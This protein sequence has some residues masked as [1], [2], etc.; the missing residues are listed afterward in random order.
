MWL[1]LAQADE[2]CPCCGEA[3][4]THKVLD[5]VVNSLKK[6]TSLRHHFDKADAVAL[7]CI[8]GSGLLNTVSGFTGGSLLID[9]LR[10]SNSS[11]Y[12]RISHRGSMQNVGLDSAWDVGVIDGHAHSH[13]VTKVTAGERL[14][15]GINFM[16]CPGRPG[17]ASQV[18][19]G[20]IFR[21]TISRTGARVRPA[22]KV[23]KTKV[24]KNKVKP[25]ARV[26]E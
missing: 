11:V 3:M 5:F 16:T 2:P 15:I 25:S 22:V 26:G 7:V 9:P 18:D 19:E 12:S 1:L 10:Y 14:S 6:L 8:P 20:N 23:K 21:S 13:G 4:S 17:R 24:K